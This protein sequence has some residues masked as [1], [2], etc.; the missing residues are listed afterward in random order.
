MREKS[1]LFDNQMAL[2]LL[3]DAYDDDDG[4]DMLNCENFLLSTPYGSVFEKYLRSIT[5]SKNRFN[6]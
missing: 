3:V 5:L 2:S 4:G 6:L 1:K